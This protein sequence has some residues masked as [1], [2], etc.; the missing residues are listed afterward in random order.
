VTAARGA[1]FRPIAA[2]GAA[3]NIG[4]RPYD[5]E[6]RAR[7]LDR[8]PAVLRELGLI[9]RLAADDLGD[10]SPRPYRDFRRPPGGIRNEADVEAYCRA[11]G[12]RVAAALAGDRFALVLGGDCSIV[13]GSLL[14]ARRVGERLGLVYVDGHADFGTPEESRTGSAASMCL[15]LAV[16]RGNSPLARLA[17]D[18]PLVRG[19]D[20]ALVGRR[21]A[22]QDYYGHAALGA[23]G[24]LDLPGDVVARTAPEA[25]AAA[26]LERV[27]RDDL[28]GFWIHV[29]ADVL[30]PDVMPAVDSPE[31]GG[32]GIEELTSLLAPLVRHPRALGLELTIYDPMLDPDRSCGARLVTLIVGAIGR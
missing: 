31:P 11:L 9:D 10:L 28:A 12:D 15:T 5:D 16:G 21:D 26:T 19:E 3:T 27:A 29:D 8:G 4:I 7:G 18:A 20:V 23:A 14:G 13:L 1:A 30:N 25:V 22:G 2:I 17:G 6:Q 24:L 32:P